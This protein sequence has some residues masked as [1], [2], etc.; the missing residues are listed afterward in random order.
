HDYAQAGVYFVTICAQ[1][2]LCLFGDIVDGA[3]QLNDAGGMTERW[4]GKLEN[5][6]PHFQCDDF[7][8][9]PNH[10][11]FVVVNVGADPCVRPG[12]SGAARGRTHVSAPTALSE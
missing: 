4:F 6:F 11:H 9:M 3:M 8:C 12:L 10:I 1:N 5:K 2:K 7:V